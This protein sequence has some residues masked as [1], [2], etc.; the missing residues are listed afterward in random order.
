MEALLLKIRNDLR[1]HRQALTT[2]QNR[3][4]RNLLILIFTIPVG[5]LMIFPFIKDW[6]SH[7]LLLIYLFSPVLY[8]QSLNKFFIGLPQKNI[9]V[10]AF[11]LVLTALST[12]TWFTNPDLTPVIFPLSGWGALTAIIIAWIML[13]W[14]FE[15][16]LPQ[17]RRYS[18][19]PHHP[20]LHIA[21]GAFM[22]AGLALHA[23]LVARFLP[24]FNLPLPALNTE[25]FVW[26]FGLFSG[27]IIPAEE[28]FFRGKLFSLLFD[29]K[30]ISLKKTIL[31]ISF[32]NLIVYL[33]ALVYLSRNPGML[34]FGVITFIYKFILSAVTVFIVY[35]WRNL[36]VGFAANLAFS[37]L[38]I[39]PFYL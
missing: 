23:L 31:W 39:Q 20:F 28:L 26:L 7:N 11:F 34:S 2:Q 25:K 3:E 19:T 12:F 29:E 37:I 13:A 10:L 17:A 15:R 16:N 21:S 38:M 18:L 32:L 5:L 9:L 14:I 36:Y 30:A 22:G 27:L 6:Q 33:P 24:N 8:L 1:G 35:R 4:W